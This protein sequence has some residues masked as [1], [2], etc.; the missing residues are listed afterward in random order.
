[1]T[2]HEE[3]GA[4]IEAAL[5]ALGVGGLRVVM[6]EAEAAARDAA[7]GVSVH[8]AEAFGAAVRAFLGLVPGGPQGPSSPAGLVRAMPEELGLPADPGAD[9][10]A[11][12]LRGWLTDDP[13]A[14][15]VLLTPTTLADERYRFPP[16]EGED[17]ARVWAFRILTP[18]SYPGL[19]WAIVDP[20]GSEASY[21]YGHD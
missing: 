7:P 10:V 12:V 18:A 19:W 4:S 15:I 9:A 3:V 17:P 20:A 2:G 13:D 14:A 1:M 6:D 11:G 21:A 16:E 8:L 5:E